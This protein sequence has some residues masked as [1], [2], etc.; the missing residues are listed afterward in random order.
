M[1]AMDAVAPAIC[2]GAAATSGFVVRRRSDSVVDSHEVGILG[3]FGDDF[4]CAVSLSLSFY[5]GD[6]HEALLGSSMHPAG[7]LIQSLIEVTD[8]KSF[9]E[10]SASMSSLPVAVAPSILVFSSLVGRCVS[11]F[12][13]V[14]DVVEVPIRS[15]F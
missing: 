8:G 13:V 14:R 6:R 11:R 2:W 9:P 1:F 3:E 4:A 15:V 12:L 10:T 7:D 5:C